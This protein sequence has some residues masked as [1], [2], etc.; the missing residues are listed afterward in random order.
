MG[1]NVIL[2]HDGQKVGKEHWGFSKVWQ[3]KIEIREY[4]YARLKLHLDSFQGAVFS[5][6]FSNDCPSLLAMAGSK[7]KLEVTEIY[8]IPS[9]LYFSTSTIDELLMFAAV[10]YA[11]WWCCLRKIQVC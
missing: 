7:G 8:N 11:L 5:V 1:K 2:K 4:V 10:G 9:L 6:S 3:V